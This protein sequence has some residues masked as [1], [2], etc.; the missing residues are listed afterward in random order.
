MT[1]QAQ[2]YR[3]PL[4]RDY[5]DYFAI[6]IRNV[7]TPK[8]C[9]ALIDRSTSQGYE[10]ALL[11]I[12]GGRQV[13]AT[14]RRKSDRCIISDPELAEEIWSRVVTILQGLDQTTKDRLLL[15]KLETPDRGAHP[16]RVAR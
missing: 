3:V 11:N 14:D 7:L 13:K 4:E 6:V 5:S 1:T 16:V 12:G 8:E 15:H 10:T 9:Q 2:V